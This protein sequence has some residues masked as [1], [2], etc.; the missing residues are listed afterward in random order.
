MMSVPQKVLALV[1]LLLLNLVV[2]GI[3]VEAAGLIGLAI[4]AVF[5]S[6]SAAFAWRIRAL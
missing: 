5:L 1:T 2:F 4:G 6:T 3:G